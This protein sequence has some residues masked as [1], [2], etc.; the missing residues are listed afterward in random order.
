MTKEQNSSSI[1]LE[2]NF[3][4]FP[5]Q[6][7]F[8]EIGTSGTEYTYFHEALEAEI[9]LHLQNVERVRIS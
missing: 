4:W 3:D 1:C 7:T 5:L 2:E 9:P 6:T 8:E